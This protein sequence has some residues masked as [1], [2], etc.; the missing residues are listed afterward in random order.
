MRKIL[1]RY[2]SFFNLFEN[3]EEYVRFSL[4]DDLVEERQVQFFLL[5]DDFQ[6]SALPDSQEDNER[7]LDAQLVFL[8]ARNS[9]IQRWATAA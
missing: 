8:H 6:G 3:V 4:L 9:R 2:T 5:F 7:Y 1:Q